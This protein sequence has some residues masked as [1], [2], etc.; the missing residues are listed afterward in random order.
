M[1]FRNFRFHTS[2]SWS[3]MSSH[4]SLSSSFSPMATPFAR[5][6]SFPSFC[7]PLGHDHHAADI[8]DTTIH[9]AGAAGAVPSLP[10]EPRP[11]ISS[12]V[13]WSLIQ[14]PTM[15]N[16]ATAT[17]T[18]SVTLPVLT[19][20]DALSAMHAELRA[21]RNLLEQMQE[22]QGQENKKTTR[23]KEV[24]V[25]GKD[26]DGERRRKYSPASMFLLRVSAACRV[27]RRRR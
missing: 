7:A 4:D 6:S 15:D 22:E 5:V 1:G 27:L 14:A 16:T 20:T 17:T 11:C 2:L 25:R 3:R 21:V 19:I 9:A 8:I 24:T 10:S 23:S 13:D 26:L 18:S 12:T